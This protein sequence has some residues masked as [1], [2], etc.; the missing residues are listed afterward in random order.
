MRTT[1]ETTASALL[2][3]LISPNVSDSNLEPANLVDVGDRLADALW[4]LVRTGKPEAVGTIEHL[5]H[6]MTEGTHAIADALYAIA[7][8]I[9][10]HGAQP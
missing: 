1:H 4:Q 3:T 2:A 10:D 8:A 9:R 6:S 5:A 7:T